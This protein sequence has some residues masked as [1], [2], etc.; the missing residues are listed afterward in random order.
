MKHPTRNCVNGRLKLFDYSGGG[1][2]YGRVMLVNTAG[3]AVK[4]RPMQ[5]DTSDF[6]G[7]PI[8][9][10]SR[11]QAIADGVLVDLTTATDDK[12]QLLCDQAGFKIPVAITRTAWAEAI[13]AGGTWR[14]DKDGEA[15]VLPGGQSL[16]GRLWDVLF[17][18]CVACGKVKD[19]DRL[20]FQVLVDEH[21]N[22]RRKVVRLWALVGPGDDSR[23]VLTIMLVGED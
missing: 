20:K 10:Y 22:G 13:E 6:W 3:G 5:N 4:T 8:V 9:A 7:E 19:S 11:A 2:V 1:R 18:L 15:L 21:G 14:T 12:G 17:M 23:A 16:T